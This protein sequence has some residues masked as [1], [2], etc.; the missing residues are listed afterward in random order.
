VDVLPRP[1]E[2]PDSIAI[3]DF[4]VFD[5]IGAYSV[6]SRSHFNGYFPDSWA[7]VE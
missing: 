1:L 3:G 7:I 2:L 6:S 5:A 4:I